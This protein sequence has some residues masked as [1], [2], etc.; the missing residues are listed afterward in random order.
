[1]HLTTKFFSDLRKM[2]VGFFVLLA[3]NAIVA[4]SSAEITTENFCQIAIEEMQQQISNYQDLIDLVNQ[5]QDDPATLTEQEEIK[6]AQFDQEKEDRY[7]SYGIT[8]QEFVLYM[9]KNAAAVDAYLE[10]NPDLK[11]QMDDLKDQLNSLAEEHTA[12]KE[13]LDQPSVPPSP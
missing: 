6:R 12:L 1:M 13:A 3:L 7:S 11:Q 4:I 9:G 2:L 5:Y 8:A 10:A